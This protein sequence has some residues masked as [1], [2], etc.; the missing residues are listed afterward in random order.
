MRVHTPDSTI[1]RVAVFRPLQLG[2]LL[3]A[4][5][6]LRAL[7]SA[8]PEARVTLIGLPWATTFVDRYPQ[9]VDDLITFPGWPGLP[10]RE[11][12]VAAIPSFLSR[13]HGASFDVAVQM[14]GNGR[15]TNT[16]V[17]M[18][19]A[20]TVAGACAD[21]AWRPDDGLFCAY[22]DDEPERRRALAALVP[23]H[24][25]PTDEALEF[26]VL[27]SDRARLRALNV[28]PAPVVLHPGS[29][30]ALRRWPAVYFAA[31]ADELASRGHPIV[32]TGTSDEYDLAREVA[33][34][35]REP[36]TVLAGKTTLGELAA[37]VD[38]SRLVLCNDTGIAH[39][40]DAL[41]V[42]SVVMF[43]GSESSRWASAN[44][45]LH[46]AV[47]HPDTLDPRRVLDHA[48]D[49]LV[50]GALHAV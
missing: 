10:E 46:R 45:S 3:C 11:P 2:D 33:E 32:I 12:D 1:E 15:L 49:L 17:A 31:V 35:M 6:A 23:L 9:Y 44:G 37:L 5:P 28:P 16:I 36:A 8:L 50:R 41:R 27:A 13:C 21:D 38:S 14:H 7:R 43:T 34:D 20:T 40:A 4:V 26:H 19:G 18:L 39:L 47:R 24:I 29:R 22:P 48:H 30:S 25:D 42:P